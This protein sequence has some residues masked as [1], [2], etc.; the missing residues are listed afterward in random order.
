MYPH[1]EYKLLTEKEGSHEELIFLD[2][3]DTERNTYVYND[4]EH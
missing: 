4:S 2:G 3:N 1:F